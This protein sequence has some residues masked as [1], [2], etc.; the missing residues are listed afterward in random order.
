MLGL[1]DKLRRQ[2]EHENGSYSLFSVAMNKNHPPADGRFSH[3]SGAAVT[4][5]K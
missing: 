4:G 5:G 1:V 2:A 3:E